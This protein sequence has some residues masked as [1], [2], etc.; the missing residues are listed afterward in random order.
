TVSDH[1]L[2]D[3]A[4]GR[5]DI[6]DDPVSTVM[7]KPLPTVGT[8]EPVEDAAAALAAAPAVLVLDGGHPVGILT[9]ADVLDHLAGR[10]R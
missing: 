7:D 4:V 8:G 1:L 3:A 6:M 9:R 5:T 2:L 10:A